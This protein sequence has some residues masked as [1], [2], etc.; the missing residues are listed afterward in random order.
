MR[1][2][3]PFWKSLATVVVAT[4]VGTLLA[5][6]PVTANA[7]TWVD[8]LPREDWPEPVSADALPTVQIGNGV[9]WGV[10]VSGNVAYAVGEF[11]TARP[12]GAA[13][14]VNEV[15]RSN[16]LTFDVTTGELLPF[17]PT[18]NA[19]V[20][21]VAV[22]PDGTKLVAVGNFTQVN[23]Q[24]RNRIAVF[25]LATGQL[26]SLSKTPELNGPASTVALT[27]TVA[28]VGGYFSAVNGESS[29]RLGAIRLTNGNI[30]AAFRTR[31]N[32]ADGVRQPTIPDNQVLALTVNNDGTK[33]MAAGNF[34][35]AAFA[36]GTGT[37]Y[38]VANG[39]DG[40]SQ[41]YGIAMFD[42]ADG[43][44]AITLPANS[45]VRNAGGNAWIF[46]L[47][48]D[49]TSAYGTGGHW[50]SNG[51]IEGAFSI[52]WTSG[53][54]NW[55]EDCHGDNYDIASV[56]NL[57][58]SASHHH[59]CGNSG[60]FS[61]VDQGG[62]TFYHSTA[63][64]K[65][66]SGTNTSDPY[67]YPDH[68]GTPHPQLTYWFPYTPSGTYTGKNQAVWTV[69]GNEQYVVYGGE[70]TS[71]NGGNQ[72]GLV[73]YTV[74]S[75]APNKQGP[76][77]SQEQEREAHDANLSFS[78]WW[79]P[80]VSAALP[81][82]LRASFPTVFDRDDTD[83]TYRLYLDT[84]NASG[85]VKEF[86]LDTP[87][88]QY[89]TLSATITGLAA[90]SSH[91]V[92]A[93][94]SDPYGNTFKSDWVSATVASGTASP[95]L[96]NVATDDIAHLW[97]LGEASGASADLIGGSNLNLDGRMTRG[98]SGAVAN[99]ADKA[100][101]FNTSS[102][103]SQNDG[104]G[105]STVRE[106]GAN[107]FT[108]ESWIKTTTT[109]GGK[110]IGFGSSQTGNSGSYDRQV[111][112]SN[113]GQIY[114]GVY[115]GEVRTINTSQSYR[116]GQWHHV[117]ATLGADG[118]KLYVDGDLKAQ[119]TDTTTAQGYQ[120]Y[121]R[122]GNDNLGGWPN[123]PSSVQ[124]E[125][126]I[127]EVAVYNEAL[128]AQRVS[129][130]YDVG[131]TG[132]MPNVAP[133]ASIGAPSV[134]GLDVAFAGTGADSDGTIGSYAWDFGDG[135]T[136]SGASVSKS[137]T[138]AGTYTVTLTVTDDDGATG[139][140]TAQVTVAP[141][142]NQAPTAQF[143]APASQGL[144]VSVDGS[145]STDPDG[146]V[147]SYAWEFGDGGTATTAAATHTYGAP[148]TYTV[149]LT[150][151]DDDG[152]TATKNAQVTVAQ[153]VVGLI[154]SDA[155]DRTV[156]NGWGTADLGGAWTL[157]GTA[158]RFSVNGGLGKIA[159]PAS[160]A[161]TVYA[162]L[163]GV[164][165]TNTRIDSVFSVDSLVEGQYVALVGRRVGTT[166]YIARLRM[167]A[168]GGVKLYLL[169][170]GATSIAPALQVPV[171]IVP[172]EKYVLSMEV[173]GTNPTTVKAKLWKQ[174]DAEPATWQR[175][176]TNSLAALQAPGAISVFTYVP[177]TTAG[178]GVSF[179]SITVKDPT[180]G[181]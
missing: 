154:A 172:G 15:P 171:T 137:Y 42:A 173:T 123:G 146:T 26:A 35:R 132:A 141:I 63:W 136:G 153:T 19:V 23:G 101:T 82:A 8:Q 174:S 65:A 97:R 37:A 78:A 34:T 117:V 29:A 16:F 7:A 109:S 106:Q 122:I 89:K 55:I 85:L 120:G 140:T 38:S 157:R 92:R 4:F 129:S 11:S 133:T 48:S 179:D 162:D 41:G 3:K 21:D 40:N 77:P 10:K 118:M 25:D 87:F 72:Q 90:G 124:F 36:S 103:A 143:A 135:T 99:D 75:N 119:R 145:A 20:K 149:K 14:G 33:V 9:I 128:S 91:Q 180:A 139:S 100:I 152:A 6:V 169:Q 22:T 102:N 27:N 47:T 150:V 70:F 80:K 158:S 159:L 79:A 121:W 155:F 178:G 83:L 108:V 64:T 49:S 43:S 126:S 5:V 164:S 112:M 163:N 96:Q 93:V 156:A 73:R 113:S 114:F 170:D 161:N 53:N 84:E 50:G 165:S 144:T 51:T 1:A 110:I 94:V 30:V 58:Y 39:R 13:P 69:D 148:G 12:A 115:P 76:R 2:N 59:Y 134:N 107:T 131:T 166:N 18:F 130:H 44:R 17:A 61:Q 52:D 160:A 151:T 104:N 45:A 68:P 28:Y 105:Y 88:W 142:P 167:Q 66:V 54:L 111:Y 177:S 67:G 176:G 95:Y 147:A 125:G 46:S 127:D 74:K 81:G 181:Q 138:A 57:V 32:D 175:E 31:F 60:G 168:D 56:G 116:D 62:W 24:T 71:V 98:Q 86:K